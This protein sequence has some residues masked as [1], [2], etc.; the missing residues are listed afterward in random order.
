[1]AESKL[2]DKSN[3]LHGR[4]EVLPT[5]ISPDDCNEGCTIQTRTS[6]SRT[7]SR[8]R[9]QVRAPVRMYL[10]PQRAT[11]PHGRGRGRARSRGGQVR[12]GHTYAAHIAPLSGIGRGQVL[13]RCM[14]EV[15]QRRDRQYFS[16]TI[17]QIHQSRVGLRTG[18]VWPL[19]V[20]TEKLFITVTKG[21]PGHIVRLSRP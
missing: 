7:I 12:P 17:S 8:I 19:S 5:E 18:P 20:G 11:M 1:M 14:E 15:L 21:V 3:C 2:D 6:P 9:S 16:A 10:G 4:D 13:G